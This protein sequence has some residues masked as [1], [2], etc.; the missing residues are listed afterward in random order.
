MYR[1]EVVVVYLSSS[2]LSKCNNASNQSYRACRKQICRSA[3][4][5]VCFPASLLIK[6]INGR[7]R[8]ERRGGEG[9]GAKIEVDG[10]ASSRPQQGMPSRFIDYTTFLSIEN[11]VFS[12]TPRS[13]VMHTRQCSR[14]PHG[15]EQKTGAN[16][17]YILTIQLRELAIFLFFFFGSQKI[18]ISELH[19]ERRKFSR[20][21]Q[22][23]RDLNEGVPAL[24]AHRVW[25][26]A[27][28]A[29]YCIHYAETSAYHNAIYYSVARVE[30]RPYVK[31]F[32]FIIL[33]LILLLIL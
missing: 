13:V 20:I 2:T 17:M 21:H 11:G 32:R 28:D 26:S 7:W 1:V 19:T 14:T 29:W 25:Y 10:A 5:G 33:V 18:I 23:D 6:Y 15:E 8:R 3:T 30:S 31:L 16:V 22:K 24:V 12:P 9:V 27:Q 4:G